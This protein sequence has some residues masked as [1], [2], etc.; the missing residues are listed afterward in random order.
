LARHPLHQTS[1]R[2]AIAAGR[3]HIA[4]GF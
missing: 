1:H 4:I 2:F 3:P